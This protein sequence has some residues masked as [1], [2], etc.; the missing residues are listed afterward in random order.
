MDAYLVY[1]SSENCQNI[2]YAVSKYRNTQYFIPKSSSW[3][4]S[5]VFTTYEESIQY[6]KNKKINNLQIIC[7]SNIINTFNGILDQCNIRQ[8]SHGYRTGLNVGL[9]YNI[10]TPPPCPIDNILTIVF[11]DEV[12]NLH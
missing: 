3:K 7:N 2:E 6:T 4:L 1:E 12:I 5:R 9:E 11:R 10:K 8:T